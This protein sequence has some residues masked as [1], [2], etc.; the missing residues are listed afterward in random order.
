VS[1]HHETI[2]L[3]QLLAALDA[4][5]WRTIG[6]RLGPYFPWDGDKLVRLGFAEKRPRAQKPGAFEYRRVGTDAV[7]VPFWKGV[8]SAPDDKGGKVPDSPIEK[9]TFLDFDGDLPDI[10]DDADCRPGP[11]NLSQEYMDSVMPEHVKERIRAIRAKPKPPE[12]RKDLVATSVEITMKFIENEGALFRGPS[13]SF[14]REIW[15]HLE[16]TWVPYTGSVP[17]PVEWGTDITKAEAWRMMAIDQGA[18]DFGTPPE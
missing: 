12:R 16:R 6:A 5:E 3:S 15:S 2:K 17:K 4:S 8:M 14:P 9:K 10:F 13:R 7:V 11:S 18:P 1:D